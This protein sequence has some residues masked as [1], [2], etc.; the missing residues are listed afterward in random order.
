MTIEDLMRSGSTEVQKQKVTFLLQIL[1]TSYWITV[2]HVMPINN[3]QLI[4]A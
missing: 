1:I 3:V 2:I 4:A